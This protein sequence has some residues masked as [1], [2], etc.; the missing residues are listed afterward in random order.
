MKV[1][2]TIPMTP[3]SWCRNPE[4]Y[5]LHQIKLKEL[6]EWLEDSG[7]EIELPED[8]GS[9][10][11]GIDLIVRGARIDLKSFGVDAYGSSY[12]WSSSYYRGRQAPISA[13]TQTDYFI[14]PAEG[15][16]ST[17]VVA[18]AKALKTSKYG[19]APYYFQSACRP[20]EKVAQGG[21]TGPGG[22]GTI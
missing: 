22:C 6:A 20:L 11:L 4:G 9:W 3:Q 2:E 13:D 15:D 7:I 5:V 1:S 8:R 14:H 16:P 12:T 18:P 21:F 19:Y 10:D 17:W